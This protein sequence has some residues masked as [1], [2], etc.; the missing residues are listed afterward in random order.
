MTTLL[1]GLI[2]FA[3]GFVGRGMVRR[4]WK[5]WQK[6]EAK[7]RSAEEKAAYKKGVAEGKD[8]AL[9]ALVETDENAAIIEAMGSEVLVAYGVD[10]ITHG[11][12]LQKAAI[13]IDAESRCMWSFY[14]DFGR[15]L[16]RNRGYRWNDAKLQRAGLEAKGK[17]PRE[18]Y[19]SYV[20]QKAAADAICEQLDE[21]DRVKA[22]NAPPKEDAK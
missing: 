21:L 5:S 17:T 8:E 7:A 13:M 19:R 12:D 1:I 2:F 3:A 15:R 18:A 4:F 10:P 9:V 14:E 20:A 16:Y 11:E 22:E 6:D